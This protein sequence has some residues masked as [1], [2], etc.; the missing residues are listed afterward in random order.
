MVTKPQTIFNRDVEWVELNRLIDDPGPGSRLLVVYGRRRQGKSLLL[1]ELAQA[2]GGLY[3]EAAQQSR[4]QNLASFSAAW[5]QWTG[6]SG[7]VRFAGWQEA[8]SIGSTRC[9]S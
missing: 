7:P 8:G 4:E 9:S 1:Q 5:G 3:W 6:A 2:R